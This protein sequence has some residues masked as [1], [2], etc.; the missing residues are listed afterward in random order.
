MRLHGSCGSG[1]SSVLWSLDVIGS[2]FS[3]AIHSFIVI[4]YSMPCRYS[5]FILLYP[6]GITSEVGLIYIA[7][8]HIKVSNYMIHKSKNSLPFLLRRVL[9][10][11]WF[12]G[13]CKLGVLVVYYSYNTWNFA[14]HLLL[15][16]SS[17]KER[18]A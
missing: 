15:V 3:P 9:Q 1:S 13:F 17:Y 12:S 11:E 10:K 18:I 14:H 7:L 4:L 8:P 6:T 5:T 16:H 2:S